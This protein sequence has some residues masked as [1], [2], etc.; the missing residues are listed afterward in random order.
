MSK[1]LGFS[2][3]LGGI[4]GTAKKEA[5]MRNEPD[6]EIRRNLGQRGYEI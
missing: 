3:H 5:Q 4:R 2:P 1:D 6:Q